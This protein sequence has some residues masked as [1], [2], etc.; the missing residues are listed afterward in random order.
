MSRVFAA[1]LVITVLA[2]PR[3]ALARQA[4]ATAAAAAETA[5][6]VRDWTRAELWAF[7]EPPPGGGDNEYA[8][9]A[10]RLQAGVR[11]RA[12]RYELSAA[13]Q[14]V[15]FGGLP[16]GAIG[17]G[18]LGLGAVYFS[19]AGR[20]DSH[21]VY[22]RYLNL[23]LKNIAPGFSVQFGRMSYSSGGEA[24]SGV[25]KIEAVKRQ[26]I[27]A[28]LIGEFDWSVYQ[29]GFDGVRLDVV[30]PAWSATGVAFHP[31]QGGFEDAA[32]LMMN[33]VM[34]IGGS[35]TAKPGRLIPGT[36]TQMFAFRYA[37]HRA[38]AARPDNSGRTA[39][40]VD[41]GINTF[42][43]TVAL[44]SPVREGRQWDGLLWVVAQTG[45]WYEQTHRAFS[46]GVEAG[47]QWDA[48]PWR[49]WIRAGVLRASGDDD[50]ADNRHG[51]FFQM[52]P[53]VRRYSQTASYSQM[54]H[55]DLFAQAMLRR[56]SS[57]GLR[58]DVHRI[59]VADARDHWYSGSG[60]TQARGDVF[61]FATRPANG[62]TDLGTAVEVSADY[63]LSPHWS[64][65]GFLGV[66]R[67]GQIV[68][69]SFSGA[70]LTFGYVENV[71][72]F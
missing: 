28:R 69:R 37:D 54:N 50:P 52:L 49:P 23:Q 5:W 25:P 32:G 8:F 4:A 19:H 46:V 17:P 40:A 59:G 11:R 7:F 70:T 2:A 26:R 65:N 22:L 62:G 64:I 10:N 42:G 39:A 31:T 61:G 30:Q 9:A 51:T 53:T 66:L 58:L 29:R 24:A 47:H 44:A 43:T 60:A 63:V 3:Y 56:G 33:D 48:V 34:V 12:P 36:E 45:A 35:A 1:V 71:I 13:L 6:F 55:T 57:F 15:H 67:G 18:P 72:Q 27:D 38:V 41:V 16:A 21:Q 20:S 68:R 14:Y